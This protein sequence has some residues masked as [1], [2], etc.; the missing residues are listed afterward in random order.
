MS[1][2]KLRFDR[3]IAIAQCR[4][5]SQH[6]FT[7]FRF[8][9]VL[10]QTDRAFTKDSSILRAKSFLI[11]QR[12][13]ECMA[14]CQ[15]ARNAFGEDEDLNSISALASIYRTRNFDVNLAKKLD[16][17]KCNP[18]VKLIIAAK[19]GQWKEAE[20]LLAARGAEANFLFD[21]AYWRTLSLR[22]C[23]MS[24]ADSVN[25]ARKAT[26]NKGLVHNGL[27][28]LDH[29]KKINRNEIRLGD[30]EL[31]RMI[32]DRPSL[33]KL[34]LDDSALFDWIAE[35]LGGGSGCGP[36]NWDNRELTFLAACHRGPKDGHPATICLA[37][38]CVDRNGTRGSM[39]DSKAIACVV[40]E[41]FNL[42]YNEYYECLKREARAGSLCRNDYA[43]LVAIGEHSAEMNTKNFFLR[44][45]ELWFTRNEVAYDVRDWFFDV[46]TVFE[47]FCLEKCSKS[48][49]PW[50]VYGIQYDLIR[51]RSQNE[52]F[53]DLLKEDKMEF[54]EESE[55]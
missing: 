9:A 3:H 53:R 6:L 34:L 24:P 4:S 14:E 17:D 7:G 44:F 39:T 35:G 46:P 25:A 54:E 32:A 10:D 13:D 38:Y 37:D 29:P 41:I 43:T 26:A 1:N 49:Y 21:D 20:V 30:Y 16:V 52:V 23:N 2:R 55:E 11:L 33:K 48:G 18:I 45:G 42:R 15:R 27:L 8:Q 31:R 51:G 36:V 22:S 19:S 5:D 28:P 12:F 40:F 47:V 50:Y